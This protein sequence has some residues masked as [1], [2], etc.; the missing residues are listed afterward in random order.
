MIAL[1]LEKT[2]VDYLFNG[3][4][5]KIERLYSSIKVKRL[6]NLDCMLLATKTSKCVVE[7]NKA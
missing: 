7:T 4:E 5:P 3:I 2:M 1:I 6:R